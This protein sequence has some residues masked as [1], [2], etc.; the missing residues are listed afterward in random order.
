MLYSD[1]EGDESK[2]NE[3]EGDQSMNTDEL[4]D[5]RTPE[6]RREA[7]LSQINTA[8]YQVSIHI[9]VRAITFEAGVHK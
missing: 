8:L 6:E 1:S 9:H 5:C 2:S 3:G 4:L 7:R